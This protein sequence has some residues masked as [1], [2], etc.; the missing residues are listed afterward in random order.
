LNENDTLVGELAYTGVRPKFLETLLGRGVE[1][2]MSMF[3]VR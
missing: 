1:I 2:D 3:E